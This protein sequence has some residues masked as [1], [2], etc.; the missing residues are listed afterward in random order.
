M[1]LIDF[2]LIREGSPV[3]DLSYFFYTGGT[4]EL[5]NKLNDFLKIYHD[6]LSKNL[7]ELGSDP[8]KLY[9]F[10]QLQ[11]DWK[12]YG[13][14]GVVLSLFI[15]K[16]KLLDVN[17]VQNIVKDHEEETSVMEGLLAASVNKERAKDIIL[18]AYESK[19]L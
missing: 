10:E 19:V 3:F 18:H 7:R 1:K 12:N 8:E 9:P 14:F 11:E 15:L 6:S 13:L 16:V 2:Q 17:D 4:K 5:F